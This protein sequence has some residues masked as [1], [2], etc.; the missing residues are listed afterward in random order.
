ML[1]CLEFV[2]RVVD[3]A[4]KARSCK[5]T[6][7]TSLQQMYFCSQNGSKLRGGRERNLT[8]LL[9]QSSTLVLQTDNICRAEV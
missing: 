2:S 5:S 8:G 7:Q 6:K 4:S 3:V 1:D 9:Q